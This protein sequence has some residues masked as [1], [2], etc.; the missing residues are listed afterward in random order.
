MYVDVNRYTLSHGLLLG[1]TASTSSSSTTGGMDEVCYL[2][3]LSLNAL[4]NHFQSFI[5]ML[6]RASVYVVLLSR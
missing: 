4:L 3:P 5:S 1:S 6:M 2:V